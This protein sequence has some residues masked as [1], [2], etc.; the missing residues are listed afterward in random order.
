MGRSESNMQRL[1]PVAALRFV[2]VLTADA[3]GWIRSRGRRCWG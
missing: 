3:K 1:M 2:S